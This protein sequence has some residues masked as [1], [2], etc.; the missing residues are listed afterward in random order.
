MPYIATLT[1]EIDWHVE[2]RK[3]GSQASA[4]AWCEG[5]GL[6]KFNHQTARGIIH[7]H[8]GQLV[9]DKSGLGREQQPE[10]DTRRTMRRIL[11]NFR[12]SSQR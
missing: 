11:A 8:S 4:I 12:T 7:A 5:E 9:W 3:F 10:R 2:Q 6:A 1:G